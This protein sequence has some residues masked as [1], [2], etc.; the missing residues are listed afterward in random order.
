M[1]AGAL[2]KVLGV[3]VDLPTAVT[4]L[5]DLAGWSPRSPC[6]RRLPPAAPGFL[7]LCDAGFLDLFF[8]NLLG[9]IW[10]FVVTLRG[11]GGFN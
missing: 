4:F 9:G 2:A 11:P 7:S 8:P 3:A 6:S 5:M 1:G 10:S